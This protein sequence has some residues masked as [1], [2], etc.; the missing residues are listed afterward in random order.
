MLKEFCLF[1]EVN[2]VLTF[3]FNCYEVQ[4]P[5]PL[6]CTVVLIINIVYHIVY[7]I[8]NLADYCMAEKARVPLYPLSWGWNANGRCGNLTDNEIVIPGHVQHSK[9]RTYVAAAAGKHHSVLISESGNM[10]SV[11]E[12]RKG[13]LG[14]G[15]MFLEDLSKAKALQ[16]YPTQV[17]PSGAYT[18][19][20]DVR[21]AQVGCGAYFSIGRE[22]SLEEGIDGVR[23]LRKLEQAMK[24]I[25]GMFKTCRVVQQAWAV[26]R[27][28]RFVVGRTSQG[29]LVAWGSNQSGQLGIGDYHKNVRY[30]VFIKQLKNINI[31]QIA[32]GQEHVLAITPDGFLYTWG[33]GAGGRLGHLDFETRF[34][35][36][37]VKF[38]ETMYVDFV[39][40]GVAHSAVLV[41][42]RKGA[43]RNEQMKRVVTFGRGAHGRLG[44]GKNRNY[45]SP[46]VV[47]KWPPS[48]AGLMWK[49]VA[50]G[51][52]HTIVLGTRRAKKGKTLANPWGIISLIYS[53]GFGM[54]GQ[55][56][57][58]YCY[59]TFVPVKTRVPK[60]EIFVEVSAGKSWSMAR[61]L[62]GDLYTWGKGMR[63]QLGQGRKTRF[64]L[65][66]EKISNVMPILKMSSGYTHNICISVPRKYLNKRTTLEAVGSKNVLDYEFVYRGLEQR[67]AVC[68]FSMSCCKR[69]I[70]AA[71]TRLRYFCEDCN[72]PS[73]CYNCAKQCHV[74]HKL[75]IRNDSS[76][77]DRTAEKLVPP[78]C[79]AR[80]TRY[81]TYHPAILFNA[82][83][84]DGISNEKV[85][86]AELNMNPVLDD[87][88]D[89]S[90]HKVKQKKSIYASS[91]VVKA[92][93]KE[94]AAKAH[95]VKA[96]RHAFVGGAFAPVAV[97]T[98]HSVWLPFAIHHYRK[99]AI[100]KR[101]NEILA[102][103]IKLYNDSAMKKY[104]KDQKKRPHSKNSRPLSEYLKELVPIPLP[105]RPNL[106]VPFCEC[107]VFRSEPGHYTT[108]HIL[109]TIDEVDELQFVKL[110]DR[111]PVTDK[112]LCAKIIQRAMRK[113]IADSIARKM[114]EESHKVRKVVCQHHWEHHILNPI[115]QKVQNAQ[116]EYRE[117]RELA[118]MAIED[119]L[120]H[121]YDYYLNLQAA[122][123]AMDAMMYGVRE[124]V[125]N[126]SIA[127]YPTGLPVIP[128][129]HRE[130]RVR[131]H[132]SN[133]PRAKDRYTTGGTIKKGTGV[134]GGFTMQVGAP[135]K[136]FGVASFATA[137][138]EDTP[139]VTAAIPVG[140]KP[141]GLKLSLNAEL[142]AI[143]DSDEETESDDDFEPV[144]LGK[145]PSMEGSSAF[146]SARAPPMV[147]PKSPS[148]LGG[149]SPFNS[150]TPPFSRV[151]SSAEIRTPVLSRA[152]SVQRMNSNSK[153]RSRGATGKLSRQASF[154][155]LGTAIN[156]A[157]SPSGTR[158]RTAIVP[159]VHVD[160]RR[161]FAFSKH[162]IRELQMDI[163][164]ALIKYRVP[165]E[166]IVKRGKYY[167]LF[168]RHEGVMYDPDMSLFTSRFVK[169][170]ATMRWRAEMTARIAAKEAKV[171]A[172]IEAKR[173][174]VRQAIIDKKNLIARAA[175]LAAPPAPKGPPPKASVEAFRLKKRQ[176]KEAARVKLEDDFVTKV[177]AE[178]KAFDQFD[179][180]KRPK[181]MVQRRNTIT[182]ADQG[183]YHRVREI[184]PVLQLKC[185]AER[186]NSLPFDILDRFHPSEK[187][188]W[189]YVAAIEDSL[190]EFSRRNQILMEFIDTETY[191][192]TLWANVTAYQKKMRLKKVL[193]LAWCTPQFSCEIL[194]KYS[195][196]TKV[197]QVDKESSEDG[198]S[199]GDEIDEDVGAAA[200]YFEETEGFNRPRRHSIGEPERFFRQFAIS[201]ELRKGV[202][203]L[204]GRMRRRD[205]MPLRRRSFDLNEAKEKCNGIAENLD[206]DYDE[207]AKPLTAFGFRRDAE[208]IEKKMIQ[209]TYW[210][211]QHRDEED[212]ISREKYLSRTYE[213]EEINYVSKDPL[214]GRTDDVALNAARYQAQEWD[215][216]VGG[217]D[218]GVTWDGSGAVV[219]QEHFS[220]EGH[221]YYYCP[222]TGESVW[223]YPSGEFDQILQQFQDEMS[224][225]WYWF[226]SVTGESEWM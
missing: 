105:E 120:K 30:P 161:T 206:L 63:G 135:V 21:I 2:C 142:S 170:A 207:P 204:R 215:G 80:R 52:A 60:W 171:Q 17:T 183:I 193:G 76:G 202:Q 219:W 136:T 150:R 220:D 159:E 217:W 114:E 42:N 82:M 151:S 168:D 149:S 129:N 139:A 38:F 147:L 130:D 140:K 133:A 125:A 119:D 73:I 90:S 7:K 8:Q 198:L 71:L 107:S 24:K 167:P 172:E 57:T 3:L 153:S 221:Q 85:S 192:D 75:Y 31:V 163:P 67:D 41:T 11:G 164:Q 175:A 68:A 20:R 209:F 65:Q 226:N 184:K 109:P 179:G 196:P 200:K 181:T 98:H 13:Q 128:H 152:N 158:Q 176:E 4:Q 88:D 25:S 10:Y 182:V 132:S 72:L 195:V 95:K 51:G 177:R 56:G 61:T 208:D 86:A 96:T 224:G 131:G 180:P 18:F 97:P 185:Y 37:K 211:E 113:C 69:P 134:T 187:P 138:K 216:T 23:G 148:F 40:A 33:R 83:P 112:H 58:G 64:S 104:Y 14:Y 143:R 115:W 144:Q 155:G 102:T 48:A 203:R 111:L 6:H 188:Q 123:A 5:N 47:N 66:P 91:T 110:G 154:R 160:L 39:A 118:D 106:P 169:D 210:G 84:L 162:S 214:V 16:C 101:E 79:F 92:H 87:E 35:P 15:N 74:S 50:C 205:N 12:N 145:M 77:V 156:S 191:G 127:L 78:F 194:Q 108:C 212:M 117:D 197:V 53:F 225:S 9:G 218:A 28:E 213:I 59:H 22:I 1:Q 201:R 223:E 45:C 121:K 126:A 19:G 173:Q 100:N 124:L 141:M 157:R 116:A 174:L 99:V 94:E 26:V 32:V 178:E 43:P 166:D 55:L 70:H 146:N 44:N 81:G 199:P 137:K 89:A 165:Q 46:V 54:N 62:A 49:Q 29:A 34:V 186:R 222:A 103:K 122:L 27:H 36:E 93:H 190:S 189:S